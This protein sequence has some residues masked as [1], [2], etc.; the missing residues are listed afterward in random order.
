ML[1]AE[2]HF[3]QSGLADTPYNPWP[4][5]LADALPL[6]NPR[7]APRQKPSIVSARPFSCLADT[8]ALVDNILSP[9]AG[10]DWYWLEGLSR[11]FIYNLI[12]NVARSHIA[13]KFRL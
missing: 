3:D 4:A 5:S 1:A 12:T 13:W 9:S 2:T 8:T 6:Q 10:S 7:V 11:D